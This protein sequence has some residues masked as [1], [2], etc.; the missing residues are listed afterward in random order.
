[1]PLLLA[2]RLAKPVIS[3]AA[4]SDVLCRW[5]SAHRDERLRARHREPQDERSNDE[6]AHEERKSC[7]LR[8]PPASASPQLA[9]L[10]AAAVDGR[11]DDRLV[12]LRLAG[13]AGA[14]AR[15]RLAPLLRDR[16]AAVV[17]FLGALAR[18][19]SARGRA[20][21]HPSPCRRSGPEPRRRASIR[22]PFLNSFIA[23]RN[24]PTAL[25]LLRRSNY[26]DGT[27][28]PV[29]PRPPGSR[30]RPCSPRTR[31]TPNRR[32]GCAGGE[33]NKR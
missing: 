28:R 7:L 16:L 4:G 29:P 6:H 24:A 9:I 12:A 20:G 11:V 27:P 22:R 13:D 25:R 26:R 17:A 30:T 33:P 18:A 5:R 2:A 3:L 23:S 15:Q 32:R 1:M 10:A 31:R 8:A 21:S 14:H 19:A